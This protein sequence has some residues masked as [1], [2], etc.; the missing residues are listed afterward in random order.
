M[1]GAG[2]GALQ[3]LGFFA[4]G[5]GGGITIFKILPIIGHF[6]RIISPELLD[7]NSSFIYQNTHFS[8]L[9]KMLGCVSLE[10]LGFEQSENQI[11]EG[12]LLSIRQG[13]HNQFLT[14]CPRGD[15]I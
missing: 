10:N 15:T 11:G 8:V 2:G 4:L 13:G 6:Q 3:I 7:L 12:T 14:F 5:G 1:L 9:L